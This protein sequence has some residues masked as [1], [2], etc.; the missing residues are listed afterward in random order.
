LKGATYAGHSSARLVL[1]FMLRAIRSYCKEHLN[2]QSLNRLL[3]TKSRQRGEL[4]IVLV[5]L[6]PLSHGHGCA[7]LFV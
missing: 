2:H 7:A 3:D 6:K 1:H 5:A 4:V